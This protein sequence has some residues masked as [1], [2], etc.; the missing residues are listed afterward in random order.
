MLVSSWSR[1]PPSSE[2]SLVL[3]PQLDLMAVQCSEAAQSEHRGAA[4]DETTI[5]VFNFLLALFSVFVL[6]DKGVQH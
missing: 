2:C 6:I 4:G 1:D 3:E 5:N